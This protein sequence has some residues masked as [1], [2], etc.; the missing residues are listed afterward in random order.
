MRAGTIGAAIAG[1]LLAVAARTGWGGLAGLVIPLFLLVSATGLIVANSIAGAL[2][3]FPGRAGAVSALTGAIQY[4]A[5]IVGSA[6]VGV[7]TDGTPWRMGVVIAL[8]SI[9]SLLC[10]LFL[11]QSPAV[12]PS[13]IR[14]ARVSTD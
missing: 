3:T 6:L 12:A 4:G 2:S 1:I 9:G 5:G 8:L 11:V 7:G 13:V 10:A 14:P